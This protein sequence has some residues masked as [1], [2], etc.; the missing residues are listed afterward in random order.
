MS[1]SKQLQNL[2]KTVDIDSKDPEQCLHQ[3]AVSNMN[4]YIRL[5]NYRLQLPQPAPSNTSDQEINQ[6]LH[7]IHRHVTENSYRGIDLDM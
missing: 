6:L 5:I 7:F 4:N 3:R 1:V 2:L